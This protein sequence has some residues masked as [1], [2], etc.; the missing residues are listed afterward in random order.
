MSEKDKSIFE[1]IAEAAKAGVDS[2]ADRARA[3]GHDIAAKVGNEADNAKDR[4]EAED[5]RTRAEQ[6]GA[7]YRR[8]MDAANSDLVSGLGQAK[9]KA[10][11][12][13][14]DVKDKAQE[15]AQEVKADV[16]AVEREADR[17]S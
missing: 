3:V 4:A 15:A 9:A 16:K 6:H 12:A 2:L 11:Q 14:A 17:H 7:E 5:A 8:E 13:A 10:D 1:N